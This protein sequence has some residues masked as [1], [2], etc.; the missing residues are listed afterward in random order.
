MRPVYLLLAV[1]ALVMGVV[2]I[3]LPLLPTVPFILLAAWAAGRSSPRL[4]QWIES[5]PRFGSHVRHWRERGAVSRPAKRA[6]AAAM[7]ASALLLYAIA[8]TW[9]AVAATAVMATVL[10]WLW[11]RPEA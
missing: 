3:F 10:A 8:P 1:A 5:H 7:A 6:A 11:Q 2:G 4:Q 9:S